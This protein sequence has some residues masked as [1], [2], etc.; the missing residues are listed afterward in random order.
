MSLDKNNWSKRG[1]CWKK[2]KCIKIPV[3]KTKMAIIS[4]LVFSQV[5]E[6]SYYQRVNAATIKFKKFGIVPGSVISDFYGRAT[7]LWPCTKVQNGKSRKGTRNVQGQ[8]VIFWEG[9]S[10]SIK[11]VPE[12]MALV[13]FD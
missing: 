10:K 3:F 7:F 12:A 9:A 6:C 13:A 1:N 5:F 4:Y 11:G 8:M 2:G